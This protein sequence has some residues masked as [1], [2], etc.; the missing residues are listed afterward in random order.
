MALLLPR[1]PCHKLCAGC[2]A[3]AA[4][5]ALAGNAAAGA[6]AGAAAAVGGLTS[7]VRDAAPSGDI[8]YPQASISPFQALRCQVPGSGRGVGCNTAMLH[9]CDIVGML[10]TKVSQHYSLKPRLHMKERAA[11]WPAVSTDTGGF[12]PAAVPTP[13]VPSAITAKPSQGALTQVNACSV[14]FCACRIAR[15]KQKRSFHAHCL[16]SACLCTAPMTP[17]RSAGQCGLMHPLPQAQTT[18]LGRR[19]ASRQTKMS[20]QLATLCVMSSRRALWWR[21]RWFWRRLP[22]ASWA[23]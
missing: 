10:Q 18:V 15:G 20:L 17:C 8:V 12:L 13:S 11:T 1:F 9:T 4:P 19:L 21:W 14:K 5:G 3:D 16:H 6:A 7:S 22:P 2:I 23:A